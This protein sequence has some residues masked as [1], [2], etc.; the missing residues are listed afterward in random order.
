MSL[1]QFLF[2]VVDLEWFDGLGSPWAQYLS[3]DDFKLEGCL[4]LPSYS[5][6]SSKQKQSIYSN[7]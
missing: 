1:S 5:Y 4:V 6:M 2:Y 3:G 7:G